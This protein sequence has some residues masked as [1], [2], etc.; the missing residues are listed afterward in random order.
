M[1][2]S[3]CLITLFFCAML[4][5]ADW[6]QWRGPNRDGKSAETGLLQQWPKGGPH[7]LWRAEGLGEG[8]S[9]FAVVAAF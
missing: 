7:L 6:P 2:R 9:S 1:I 3:V 5:A 8:Y 4:Q